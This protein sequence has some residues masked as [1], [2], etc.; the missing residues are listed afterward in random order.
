VIAFSFGRIRASPNP[1]SLA[2]QAKLGKPPC[3][4][5]IERTSVT[6]TKTP[7]DNLMNS[8]VTLVG[9]TLLFALGMI[10]GSLLVKNPEW[11]PR[12]IAHFLS[13]GNA[14]PTQGVIGPQK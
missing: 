6:D 13:L 3:R 11:I 14:Y 4:V 10:V 8:V 12:P 5:I 9:L 7:N 1:L 2:I